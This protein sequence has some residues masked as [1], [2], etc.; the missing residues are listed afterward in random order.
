MSLLQW[1]LSHGAAA[2][3]VTFFLV[4]LVA[5]RLLRPSKQ[6]ATLSRIPSP[7]RLPIV[8]HLHLV[9]SLPHVSLRDLAA[10]H[11]RDGL[12]LLR[13]GAVPTLVVS[14]PRAPR[15]SSARTTTSSPPAPSTRSP[16]S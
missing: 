4:L 7:P 10:R 2:S 16:T 13:L 9:G 11:G 8:G 6:L 1:C 14:S 12:M 5:A 3:L 15:P